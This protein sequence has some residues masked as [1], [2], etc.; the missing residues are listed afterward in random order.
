VEETFGFGVI[1][2]ESVFEFFVQIVYFVSLFI[3][4]NNLLQLYLFLQ[5][6]CLTAGVKNCP[7]YCKNIE[8]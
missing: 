8:T 1:V 7:E 6:Q 3:S 5:E 4:E 2:I